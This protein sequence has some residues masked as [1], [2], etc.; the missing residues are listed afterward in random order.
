MNS[1]ITEDF[2]ACF[3]QLPDHIKDRA[4]KCY[5]LWRTDPHHPSLHFKRLHSRE[6]LYSVR[7]GI[8]WRVLGLIEG[9]TMYWFWIGSH[10]DYDK[11]LKQL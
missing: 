9:D 10:S 3:A 1:R 6:H 8:G 2:V 7:V 4:R 5:R 11:F